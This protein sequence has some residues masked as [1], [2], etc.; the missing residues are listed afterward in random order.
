MYKASTS[1]KQSEKKLIK[2]DR[3]LLQRLCKAAMAGRS[4]QIAENLKQELS[5]VPLSLAK[6]SGEMNTTSKSELLSL[7]TTDMDIEKA[8]ALQDGNITTCVL[9]DGHAMIQAMGKPQGCHTFG[10]Y[11]A[12]AVKSVFKHLG[13][14]TTCVDITFDRYLGNQ[15]RKSS[16]RS[17][18]TG[19]RKPIRKLFQGPDVPLPQVW[20]QLIALEDNKADL[21]FFLSNEI[22][23]QAESLTN[24]CEVIAGGGF[25]DPENARSSRRDIPILAANHE[26]ADTR[27]IVHAKDAWQNNFQK[28]LV[29]C[30]DTDVLLLL[31]LH[32]GRLEIE[33]WMVSGTSKQR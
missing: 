19:K 1:E 33:V 23:H 12:V 5:P 30:R 14:T 16:I 13:E 31:L 9:I 3:K 32:L 26:E 10:D 28:I 4:V 6:A 27:L 2:A 15:P 17:K 22:L 29:M 8:S 24:D 7:L 20:N 11:I 25:S 21:A 18:R